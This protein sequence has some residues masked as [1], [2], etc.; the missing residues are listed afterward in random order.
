[1]NREEIESLSFEDSFA[2]LERVIRKMETGDLS[3]DDS[4]SLY[5]EGMRLA[6]H[7]GEE[8][9][10]AELR[11]NELLAAVA[12]ELGDDSDAGQ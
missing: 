4:V 6:R 8:L 2:R 7:C 10:N 5:E 12:D 1:M 9:D 3:L 11:V